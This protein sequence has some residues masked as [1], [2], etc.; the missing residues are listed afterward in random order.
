MVLPGLRLSLSDAGD[1]AVGVYSA[2]CGEILNDCSV[3]CDPMQRS[4][5]CDRR[6]CQVE[7]KALW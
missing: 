6:S 1:H 4:W 7:A 5:F 3:Y 2:G